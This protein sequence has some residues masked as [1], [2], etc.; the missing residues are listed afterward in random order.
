MLKEMHDKFKEFKKYHVSG[1]FVIA[2]R[3]YYADDFYEILREQLP[4]TFDIS[5]MYS[6]NLNKIIAYL[7]NDRSFS[8]C[9]IGKYITIDP[10]GNESVCTA[11]SQERTKF[12]IDEVQTPCTN[13][14][15]LKC[16]YS[17]LCDGGC[18][19]ER[20]NKYKS[21]W[22]SNYLKSTCK[23]VKIYA[24]AIKEFLDQ[25]TIYDRYRLYDIIVEY[26]A[27]L[28]RYYSEVK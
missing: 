11:L 21:E 13:K 6:D 1:Q 16:E 5:K 19:Y 9:D 3:D 15:C 10:Y 24:D 26:K 25:L 17:Y 22:K 4:Y 28:K 12:D 8:S 18:R 23:V 2:H 14:D 20:Y 7:N 27:Y